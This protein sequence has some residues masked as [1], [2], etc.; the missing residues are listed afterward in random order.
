V[1]KG[2]NFVLLERLEDIGNK[3]V[4]KKPAAALELYF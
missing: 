4:W 1:A 3:N 2:P